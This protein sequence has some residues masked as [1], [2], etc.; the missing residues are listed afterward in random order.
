[1]K[2]AARQSTLRLLNSKHAPY[3]WHPAL[4]DAALDLNLRFEKL[5]DLVAS[6]AFK[7]R[8]EALGVWFPS[9]KNLGPQD[10]LDPT[11]TSND[12]F[13]AK[14]IRKACPIITTQGGA[15]WEE[16][17]EFARYQFL[18]LV[19]AFK[20]GQIENGS[21]RLFGFAPYLRK[22]MAFALR[23]QARVVWRDS[24]NLEVHSEISDPQ[25]AITRRVEVTEA[26]SLAVRTRKDAELLWFVV[27]CGGNFGECAPFLGFSKASA[28]RQMST[29]IQRIAANLG[30]IDT[31]EDTARCVR[32]LGRCLSPD[33]L[34]R[35]LHTGLRIRGLA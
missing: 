21:V 3:R 35:C 29:I 17:L 25:Q 1:M 9:L 11:K 6:K 16:M 4:I 22:R 10:L 20:P 30:Q 2:L 12:S 7:T 15:R 27:G 26:V 13:L 28:H 32:E 5:E 8:A 18:V 31:V 33:D 24:G 19:A 23:D 34:K 14:T